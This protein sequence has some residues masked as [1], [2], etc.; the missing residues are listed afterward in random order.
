MFNE[1]DANKDGYISEK[2]LNNLI[3][4]IDKCNLLEGKKEVDFGE[5]KKIMMRI[6]NKEKE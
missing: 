5:F 3:S 4:G 6:F 1:M 2:E